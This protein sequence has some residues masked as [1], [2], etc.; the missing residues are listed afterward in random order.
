MLFSRREPMGWRERMRVALWPRRSIARST[1]YVVKRV[2]R[3]SASPHAVAAGV[4]AGVAASFTP[5]MG[6]HF[7]IS[8]I[9]AYFIAGNIIAAA[10]GTFV[11]NPFTFPFI[12]IGTFTT[13]RFVL[14]GASK[15]PAE[16][17]DPIA[18]LS[19]LARIDLFASG[20][21]GMWQALRAIWEPVLL[22]MTIGSIPLGILFGGLFYI[23]TRWL[24][25]RFRRARQ[26]RLA[27]RADRRALEA[28]QAAEAA[29]RE[30]AAGIQAEPADGSPQDTGL[31][32]GGGPAIR[33]TAPAM[34]EAARAE[35]SASRG[36]EALVEASAR[37]EP[38]PGADAGQ[39]TAAAPVAERVD[40]APQPER[41]A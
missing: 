12:W 5:F 2:L 3:L 21:H 8:F 37:Q 16:H 41:T 4:A 32:G 18:H 36:A 33:E 20:L 13:G 17:V 1:Q 19:D 9:I 28:R 39:E 22:P 29:H 10:L 23:A 11:G 27:A 40:E 15:A 24:V 6:F 35:D 38:R 30:A 26:R 14:S 31:E 25:V 34:D 7:I